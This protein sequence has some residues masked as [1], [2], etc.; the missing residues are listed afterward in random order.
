MPIQL[1]G[2]RQGFGVTPLVLGSGCTEIAPRH[3][4]QDLCGGFA[5]LGGGSE[6]FPQQMHPAAGSVTN[7]QPPPGHP[8]HP[9]PVP[10]PN[11]PPGAT[12]RLR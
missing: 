11:V 3:L 7:E 12:L 10:V 5:A 2:G 9:N 8:Q 4:Q 1:G 6:P